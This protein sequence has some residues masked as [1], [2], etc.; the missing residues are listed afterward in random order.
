ME[1]ISKE[2]T[3]YHQSGNQSRRTLIVDDHPICR[4]GLRDVL[5]TISGITISAEAESE[6][7]AFAA[8]T[9]CDADLVTIDISLASGS[10]LNLISR[11]KN[12]R[13]STIVLAVSMYE[14][15]IYAE[16]ALAAGAAGYV[17]KHASRAELKLALHT[18]LDGRVF[19]GT[20]RLGQPLRPRNGASA[21]AKSISKRLSSRELQILTLIGQGRTTRQ[22]ADE[23]KLVVST[24]ET[25]RERLKTKMGLSTGSELTRHA[26][27]WSLQTTKPA[28]DRVG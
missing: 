6:D 23:L 16:L 7:D 24:V 26:I 14:D 1:A 2:W 18:V 8:F 12:H 3:G 15:N 21:D 22:I 25:Y 4:A 5:E 28:A 17:C 10:G 9:R 27:L 19:V 13:P 20:N 11:I